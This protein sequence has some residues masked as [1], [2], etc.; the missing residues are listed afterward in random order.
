MWFTKSATV[1]IGGGG[2]CLSISVMRAR[3]C[4]RVASVWLAGPPCRPISTRSFAI[5]AARSAESGGLILT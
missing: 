2:N 1:A 5:A 3:N 4:D